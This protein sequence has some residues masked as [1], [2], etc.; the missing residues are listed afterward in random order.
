MYP[1][2]EGAYIHERTIAM[3]ET[4]QSH[5]TIGENNGNRGARTEGVIWLYTRQRRGG[6]RE[7]PRKERGNRE[8]K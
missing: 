4:K 5:R 3:H 6:V 1:Q 7:C 8:R 2:F